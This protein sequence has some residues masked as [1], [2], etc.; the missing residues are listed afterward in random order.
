MGKF[1]HGITIKTTK[2]YPRVSAGPLRFEYVHRVVAAAMIGRELNK[3]EEVHHRDENK[4]NFR[5]SNLII[6][7]SKDHGWVSA[8][9]A[10]FMRDKDRREKAE[11][12]KFMKEESDRFHDEVAAA[13]AEGQAWE[14]EDGHIEER[15]ALREE[16]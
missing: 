15:F 6:Y 7:G 4:L 2:G 16:K 10:H 12:D 13:K 11:W 14:Y 3:D 5:W 8:K 9:Q 1:R